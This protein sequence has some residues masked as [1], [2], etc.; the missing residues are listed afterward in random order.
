MKI[1][2]FV[3]LFLS[4]NCFGKEITEECYEQGAFAETIMDLRIGGMSEVEVKSM[5]KRE[6]DKKRID[7]IEFVFNSP[8]VSPKDLGR[9]KAVVCQLKKDLRK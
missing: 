6:I 5:L 7:E 2:L 1:L 9:A 3:L 8:V 4:F